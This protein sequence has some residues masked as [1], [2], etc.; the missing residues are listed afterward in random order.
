VANCFATDQSSAFVEAIL[1]DCCC[2]RQSIQIPSRPRRNQITAVIKHIGCVS[3]ANP[4]RIRQRDGYELTAVSSVL[5]AYPKRIRQKDG[6]DSTAVPSA[7][8]AYPKRIRQRDG[9]ESTAVSSVSAAYPRCVV[10]AH[11][12]QTDRLRLNYDCHFGVVSAPWKPAMV[13]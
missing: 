8:A 12:R 10:E 3:K 4:K 5:A 1:G 13:L 11:D 7:S 2:Q 6:N 9:Y